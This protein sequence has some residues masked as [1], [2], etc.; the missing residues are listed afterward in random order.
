MRVRVLLSLVVLALTGAACKSNSG[1]PTGPT[2]NNTVIYSAVGASDGIGVGG[3]VVCAPLDPTCNGTGYVFLLARRMR[4]EGR[5]VTLL[6]LS[7]P[8]AVLSPAIQ[9]LARS[10]GRDV[11]SN[12]LEGQAP[13]I[14]TAGTPT[15]VTVFA[16]GNDTNTIGQAVRAGA[17]GADIRG[18]IDRQVQ[19]FGTDYQEMLQRMRTRAPNARFVIFNLPNLAAAPYVAANTVQER[20]ILQRIAV[21]ITDRTNALAGS[22]VIVIDLMCDARMYDPA[23]YSSDG[24]HPN[25]RGYSLMADIAYPALANGTGSSP[26]SSCPQRTLLPVF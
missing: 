14:G 3:T 22:N 21:G 20:S 26:S 2:P 8:G 6:N 11:L 19:Q 24:F 17:G 25:D 10:I 16:G 7:L 1:G 15:H 12:F 23:N 18:F 9:N 4:G 5:E 13:F